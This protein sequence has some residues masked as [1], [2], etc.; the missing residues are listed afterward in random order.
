MRENQQT[1]RDSEHAVQF[2]DWSETHSA[3]EKH[4]ARPPYASETAM[5]TMA[6]ILQTIGSLK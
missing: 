6:R 3:C 4:E 5:A 2:G 1:Q